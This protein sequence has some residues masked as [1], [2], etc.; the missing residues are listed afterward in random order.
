VGF[1]DIIGWQTAS[2]AVVAHMKTSIYSFI[3]LASL[4]AGKAQ[5][6][7]TRSVAVASSDTN[8][9]VVSQDANSRVWQRTVYEQGPKGRPVHRKHTYT[10]LASGLNY[11]DASGKWVESKELIEPFPGGAIARHGQHKVIFSNNLN[12]IG[13]IDL[14]GPDGKRLRSTILGLAYVDNSTGNSVMIATL[15]D[16]EGELVSDNQVLYPNAFNG[17]KADVRY[18]Y[19]R[20]NFE[21]DVVLQEQPPSPE[22]YGLNPQTTAL[23]VLTEFINT[24]EPQ[25][26]ESSQ[27]VSGV[28][29]DED[30]R[31]GALFLG[32]SKAF[33]W[34]NEG[35]SVKVSKR[36]FKAEGRTF[37]LEKV[38]YLDVK[39]NLLSLPISV[40]VSRKAPALVSKSLL[41]PKPPLAQANVKPM[42][43]AAR[44]PSGPAYVLDYVTFNDYTFYTNYTF[45]GDTTYFFNGHAFFQGTTTIEGGAVSKYARGVYVTFFGP[46]NCQTGP[47]RPAIFTAIDDNSVGAAISGSTGVPSGVYAFEAFECKTNVDLEYLHINYTS[48]GI[49]F[50]AG[51]VNILRNCQF[52]NNASA[53]STSASLDVG[54][55]L[56]QNGA[57]SAFYISPGINVTAENITIHNAGSVVSGSNL[58]IT[59]SLFIC[60]TN[61]ANGFTG[62]FNATNSSDAGVFQVA[63]A[64]SH[65]LSTTSIYHNAGTPNIPAALLADL[66]AKTTYPPIIYSNI[67]FTIPTTLTPQA[68]RYTSA[69]P[70][71]G[72]HYDP[73]DYIFGGVNASANITVTAGTAVGWFEL[74]G[75]GGPGYGL[76]LLNGISATFIGTATVPCAF[77]RYSAVQEGG[78]G[79]WQDKG[80]LGG[81][82]NVDSYDPANPAALIT[83]FTHFSAPANDSNLFRDGTDGQP[84]IV[85]GTDDELLNGGGGYNLLISFTNCLFLRSSIG[86]STSATYPYEI[87][88]NCTFHGGSLGFG[89]WESGPPYWYSS[90]SDCAFEGTTFSIDDP[91]G[92]DTT[93]ANYNYNAFLAGA[94]Q[95]PAEGANTINVP[96][97]NWQTSW[98]GNFYLPPYSALIDAGNTTADQVGLYHFTTQTNQTIEGSSPVDI[99][100]HYVATDANGNPLDSNG[101]GIPDYAEDVNGN[102]LVDNGET[103]WAA[104]PVITM[105]PQN[106]VV[107]VSGTAQF[108]V[109]AVSTL[110]VTYQWRQSGVPIAGATT[111]TLTI[112]NAQDSQAA[113]Y[114]VVVANATGQI[115][116]TPASLITLTIS[117]GYPYVTITAKSVP[118]NIA[119]EAYGTP[120]LTLNPGNGFRVCFF[121]SLGQSKL[122]FPMPI[123]SSG[124]FTAGST[125]DV[126]GDGLTAGYEYFISGSNP[127]LASTMNDGIPDGWKAEWGLD[128]TQNTGNNA[129]SAD[130]DNDGFSNLQEYQNGTDPFINNSTG[131]PRPVITMAS[132]NVVTT[133][134]GADGTFL[135]SRTGSTAADLYVNYAVG[136]TAVYNVDYSLNPNPGTFYPFSFKIPAGQASA[137]L[138]VHS[139]TSNKGVQPIVIG[140][141]PIAIADNPSPATWAYV[142]DPYHDRAAIAKTDNPQLD[143]D[144]DGFPDWWETL[145]FGHLGVSPTDDPNQDGFTNLQDYQLGLNPIVNQINQPVSQRNYTYDLLN[146]LTQVT[147]EGKLGIKP[148]NEGNILLVT[149]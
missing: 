144:N 128:P 24:P 51:P 137:T 121:G 7:V 4:L 97:Y 40:N 18:T 93:Y 3:L 123:W 95:P 110:P 111:D 102:G 77:V 14:E 130:P 141:V 127:L 84:L 99:G 33:E 56:I 34:G 100:Y 83:S 73:L 36:L 115:K 148:D 57:Y 30:I 44:L 135:I 69:A 117:Y 16:S 101:D 113:I 65:Y 32:K 66:Q 147:H 48:A 126:D 92:F 79:L 63:G 62:S 81:I 10:E 1:P 143:S 31:W 29:S 42:K 80:W 37:L 106:Q 39:G 103:S 6:P 116:S 142:V 118:A 114:D 87:Y 71:L 74:P 19:T 50:W 61:V 90:L 129:A 94:A 91:F 125:E 140:L 23:E 27:P 132:G 75:N 64:G 96:F 9:T 46:V 38:K 138:T 107:R 2:F 52:N 67:N 108:H 98:F 49:N 13:A 104:L 47:Y 17:V 122:V 5:I 133:S 86:N 146:R 88:R 78:N 68:L 35:Q 43:L 109:Q 28:E 72:Y 112:A 8:Y 20:A 55:V 82:V 45:Q 21:Q 85:Q 54:N 12:T 26:N 76:G 15:Q 131:T 89:H 124:F 149:P 134:G 41:L 119:L 120:N 139:L 53:I 59:N 145:Y 60:V 58:S 11:R 105:Q 136:G 25:V 22:A 70:D